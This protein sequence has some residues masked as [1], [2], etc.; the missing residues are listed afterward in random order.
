[1][2]ATEW[3]DNVKHLLRVCPRLLTICIV[4]YRYVLVLHSSL[5]ET[6]LQKRMFE[7]LILCTIFL[8][9]VLNSSFGVYYRNHYH[10]Y[11]GEEEKSRKLCPAQNQCFAECSKRLHEFYYD[12]TDF[13]VDISPPRFRG[14]HWRL[15]PTNPFRFFQYLCLSSSFIV[16]PFCYGSIYRSIEF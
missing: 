12:F 16:V 15:P 1:M 10:N 7:C 2:T 14:V 5:V 9:P 4:I 13:Y 8:L 3:G 6:S 11:L